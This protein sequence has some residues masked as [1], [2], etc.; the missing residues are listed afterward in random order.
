MFFVFQEIEFWRGVLNGPLI[1][2]FQYQAPVFK[3]LS[4][5]CD[6]LATVSAACFE[7]LNASWTFYMRY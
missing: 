2:L 6:V 1:K 7:C 4:A 3:I 5:A